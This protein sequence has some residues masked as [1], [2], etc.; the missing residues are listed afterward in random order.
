[1]EWEKP[2]CD[3]LLTIMENADAG[4]RPEFLIA[5]STLVS[6]EAHQLHRFQR[7]LH[8]PTCAVYVVDELYWSTSAAKFPTFLFRRGIGC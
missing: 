1:M 5:A 6:P 8:L 2:V 4:E 3:D 7:T